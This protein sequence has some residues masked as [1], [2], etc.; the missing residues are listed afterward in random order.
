MLRWIAKRAV[1]VHREDG[2][3]D[4][5][6]PKAEPVLRDLDSPTQDRANFFVEA[7]G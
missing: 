1:L 3:G 6:L 4:L 5:V 2:E 7:T